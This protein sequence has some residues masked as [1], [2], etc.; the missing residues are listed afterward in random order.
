[1]L[2]R[3]DHRPAA[4]AVGLLARSDLQ[5]HR[6]LCVVRRAIVASPAGPDGQGV[7]MM[8][9]GQAADALTVHL[10][11]VGR[12]RAEGAGEGAQ[13]PRESATPHPD[14]IYRCDPTSPTRGEVTLACGSTKPKSN[15]HRGSA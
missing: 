11:P 4:G 14:R 10:S 15:R 12:G 13:V 2:C 8:K 9:F 6:R 5:G 1:A 3:I 7:K